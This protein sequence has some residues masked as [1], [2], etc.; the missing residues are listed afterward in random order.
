MKELEFGTADHLTTLIQTVTKRLIEQYSQ[1]MCVTEEERTVVRQKQNINAT[2][3]VF[4]DGSE[5]LGAKS[6]TKL[7]S[8]VTTKES[9]DNRA[10]L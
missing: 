9:E 2:K 3:W 8:N 1:G 7:A 10:R 4:Y 5:P 6:I